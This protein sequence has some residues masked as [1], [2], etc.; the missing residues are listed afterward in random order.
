MAR[1]TPALITTVGILTLVI[2][3]TAPS[4]AHAD[5]RLH[6]EVAGV[7]PL[8]EV[9]R[10]NGAGVS[11]AGSIDYEVVD[12]LAVGAFYSFHDF[13][14][15][16][17]KN[18]FD[19]AVGVRL[20]LRFVRHRTAGWFG[21]DSGDAYGEAFIELDL[22][23]H[24]LGLF[25]RIGWSVGLGYRV[26]VADPFGFGPFFR[27]RHIVPGFNNESSRFGHQFY[28][29]FGLEMF[30][31]FNLTGEDQQEAQSDGEEGEGGGEDEWSEFEAVTPGDEE[32]DAE[33]FDE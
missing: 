23:Y 14:T 21:N 26:I 18:V 19:H 29:V 4:P 6:T 17:D 8:D 13:I 5:L 24:N 30:L 28:A 2:L 7:A 31:S 32:D 16:G 12:L 25:S 27:F 1:Q 33:T 9:L 20:D 10:S 11:F 22:A 3:L 15:G